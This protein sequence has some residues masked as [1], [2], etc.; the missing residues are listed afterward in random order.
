MSLF[1]GAPI[2]PIPPTQR[3]ETNSIGQESSYASRVFS[4]PPVKFRF[5]AKKP[6]IIGFLLGLGLLG[7]GIYLGANFGASMSA[8][9]QVAVISPATLAPI[10][11]T[12]IDALP[13]TPSRSRELRKECA[14]REE[15]VDVVPHEKRVNAPQKLEPLTAKK[16]PLKNLVHERKNDLRIHPEL[17]RAYEFLK[18][19]QWVEAQKSYQSV[20]HDDAANMDALL[21]LASALQHQDKLAEARSAYEQALIIDPSEAIALSALLLLEGLEGEERTTTISKAENQLKEAINRD[22]RLAL[23]Y[24]ALGNLYAQESRWQEAQRAF[25]EAFSVEPENADYVFNMAVSL[26]HLHQQELALHYY[27]SALALSESTPFKNA[28]SF[29]QAQLKT[30]ISELKQ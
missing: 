9:Q 8:K 15:T 25:F 3:L 21:G 20:L 29:S 27:L 1:G 4:P 19:N 5:R 11:P 7:I 18:N 14:L 30:R 13:I 22:P 26:D 12:P 16:D 10:A 23:P 6:L 24:F 17:L 28:A 2:P